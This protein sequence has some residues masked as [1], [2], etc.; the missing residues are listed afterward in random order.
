MLRAEARRHTQLKRRRICGLLL[1]RSS[2]PLSG[3]TFI[4]FGGADQ[5]GPLQPTGRVG[6]GHQAGIQPPQR[7][8]FVSDFG[9]RELGG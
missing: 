9:E 3:L 4:G 8:D 2:D 7:G 5:A 6:E 1:W